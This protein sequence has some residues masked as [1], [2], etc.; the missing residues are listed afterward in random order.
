LEGQGGQLLVDFSRVVKLSAIAEDGDTPNGKEK[1]TAGA[2]KE[3]ESK[4]AGGKKGKFL[5]FFNFK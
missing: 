4:S 5:N 1:S 2:K 3:K